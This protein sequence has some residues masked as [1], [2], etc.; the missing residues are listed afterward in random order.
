M[1]LLANQFRSIECHSEWLFNGA[2]ETMEM[3]GR[4]INRESEGEG[5]DFRVGIGKGM[6]GLLGRVVIFF[7]NFISLLLIFKKCIII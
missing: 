7:F 5:G 6:M 4:G 3:G 1:L 2:R